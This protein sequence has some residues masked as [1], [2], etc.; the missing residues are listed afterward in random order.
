MKRKTSPVPTRIW[1]FGCL[2]PVEG[3]ELATKL[4]ALSHEYYNTLAALE[5]ESRASYR[6]A[7]QKLLPASYAEIEARHMELQAALTE[8]RTDVKE[9]RRRATAATKLKGG[10]R[11]ARAVPPELTARIA[12]LSGEDKPL[13]ERLRAMREKMKTNSRLRAI[14]K[15]LEEERKTKRKAIRAGFVERGLFWGDYLLAEKA[16]EGAVQRSKGDIRTKRGTGIEGRVGVQIQPGV[17]LKT[18]DFIAG[19]PHTSLM[20]EPASGGKWPLPKTQWDTRSGRRSAYA[21]V[22][23]RGG[24][25]ENRKPVWVKFPVLLHR[26]L[27]EGFIKWAWINVYKVGTRTKY[28]LQLAIESR[29]FSRLP[30]GKGSVAVWLGWQQQERVKHGTAGFPLR[31]GF[32]VDEHG[33]TMS[34]DMTPPMVEAI[35]YAD[36]LRE[37]GDKMFNLAKDVLAGELRRDVK[38]P[39]WVYEETSTVAQWRSSARLARVAFRLTSETFTEDQISS[40]WSTWKQ[41]R[42]AK[43]EDLFSDDPKKAWPDIQDWGRAHGV[44]GPAKLLALYLEWWRRKNRHLYQWECDQRVKSIGHRDE[45]FR[46]FAAVLARTYETIIVRE[47]DF[48]KVARLAQPEAEQVM[49]KKVRSNRQLAAPG[50]LRSCIVSAAGK[51]RVKEVAY[52]ATSNDQT[53]DTDTSEAIAK[54]LLD[55][56]YGTIAAA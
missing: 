33:K 31:V 24:S 20:L 5:N 56:Y 23:V 48:A 47:L 55:I 35:R 16:L 10:L 27:P 51:A 1:T 22:C 25:T 17:A 29:E 6:D 12:K 28:E 34:C 44:R 11:P 52:R 46:K 15:R 13:R 8:A 7:R 41:E 54:A 45:E 19:G 14:S 30:C 36:V 42:Q 43:G 40:L 18:G 2:P 38:V 21:T 37:V 26:A 32:A 50:K 4:L 53:S 9:H 49:A 39:A 3:V